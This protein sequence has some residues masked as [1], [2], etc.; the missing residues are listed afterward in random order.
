[1]MFWEVQGV[2]PNEAVILNDSGNVLLWNGTSVVTY[3]SAQSGR[4][5]AI[6]AFG[7]ND[8]WGV[9]RYGVIEHF[10]GTTWVDV[11]SQSSFTMWSVWGAPNGDVWVPRS[12]STV[13]RRKGP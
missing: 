13:I 11:D 7:I 5:N 3:G 1:M 2:G 12:D 8:I 4:L 6:W 10:D 9:G